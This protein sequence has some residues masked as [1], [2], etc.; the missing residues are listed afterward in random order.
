MKKIVYII[1]SMVILT[2]CNTDMDRKEIAD[3]TINYKTGILAGFDIGDS[4]EKVKNEH[5]KLWT[6]DEGIMYNSN[7]YKIEKRWGEDYM[8]ITFYLDENKK[9]INMDLTLE[10]SG[11]NSVTAIR[12]MNNAHNYYGSKGLKTILKDSWWYYPKNGEKCT[13]SC[14]KSDVVDNTI[15]HII[16][17][18]Q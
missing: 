15:V 17:A 16:I 3:M 5:H 9:I 1:L 14:Y 13:I 2:S 12:F 4:W 7:Y 11:K 6:V 10:A 18:K 8:I